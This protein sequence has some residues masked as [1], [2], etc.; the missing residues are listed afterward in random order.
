MNTQF[1]QLLSKERKLIRPQLEAAINEIL[2][3][4]IK[5]NHNFQEEEKKQIF[6]TMSALMKDIRTT[7]SGLKGLVMLLQVQQRELAN[8]GEPDPSEGS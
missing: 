5:I 2:Q 8:R 4:V 6:T 7:V 1:T 3:M